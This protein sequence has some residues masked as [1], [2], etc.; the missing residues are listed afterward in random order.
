VVCVFCVLFS[1]FLNLRSPQGIISLL[2]RFGASDNIL[3]RILDLQTRNV[4]QNADS[5]PKITSRPL[6]AGSFQ[7]L[8]AN[9]YFAATSYLTLLIIARNLGMSYFGRY[10]VV[11]SILSGIELLICDSFIHPLIS[12]KV[13]NNVNRVRRLI[14]LQLFGAF[15]GAAGLAALAKP[16]A[17]FFRDPVLSMPFITA[18][19]DI[20]PFAFFSISRAEMNARDAY[21]HKMWAAMAY[22]TA[23][24]VFM[25]SAAII[26]GRPA[27]VLGGMALASLTAALFSRRMMS[28]TTRLEPCENTKVL[29][30]ES[31]GLWDAV[32]MAGS[33]GIMFGA[34]LWTLKAHSYSGAVLSEYGAAQN[35]AKIMYIGGTAIMW[36]MIPS[37]ARSGNALELIQGRQLRKLTMLLLLG[38]GG[39]TLIVTSLPRLMLTLLFGPEFAG[40]ALFLRLLAPAYFMLVLGM[41]LSQVL[42]HTFSGRSLGVLFG[43]SAILLFAA[44]DLGVRLYGP[45]GVVAGPSVAG[46]ALLAG[47]LRHFKR[48]KAHA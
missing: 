27:P 43:L 47:A 12:A 42:F 41:V 30:S 10:L 16:L 15:L 28:R 5:I 21:I 46:L 20:V 25:G 13:G 35:L 44:C 24:L 17:V 3:R 32:L 11:A 45:V 9:G 31:G 29:K 19:F 48:Q 40:G 34:D 8:F 37:V 1:D 36:P 38:L 26:Y 6:V 22:G 23:K 39:W 33:I 18:A 14:S 4:N 7:Q 2:I